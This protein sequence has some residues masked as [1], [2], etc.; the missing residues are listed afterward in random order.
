MQPRDWKLLI[1]RRA[2]KYGYQVQPSKKTRKGNWQ[3]RLAVM[4][5]RNRMTD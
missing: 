4:T 5:S 2:N 3:G 1:P